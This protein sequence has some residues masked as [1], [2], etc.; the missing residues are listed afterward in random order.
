MQLTTNILKA[1]NPQQL[2][3]QF[4]NGMERQYVAL[5]MDVVGRG[6]AT[7]SY[8]DEVVRHEIGGFPVGY[9]VSMKVF[10]AGPQFVAQVQSDH[11]L[12]LL[13]DYDQK[14]DLTITFKHMHHAFLVF[15]F[16]ESTARAFANDRMIADGEVSA[17]IRLVRCLNRMEAL[18]L[19]KAI[20]QL[21]VKSYPKDL[22]FTSKLRGATKIY[23]RVAQSYL[24]RST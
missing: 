16:Q 1:F 24:H 10:P 17:A 14:P 7:A 21:A 15:S 9:V 4:K 22:T 20:A 6:L 18:I 12:K 19:P 3:D 8:T 13:N 11:G 5:M 2:K 23:T